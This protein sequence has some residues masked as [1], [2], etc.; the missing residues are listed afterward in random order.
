MH[1]Y[2]YTGKGKTIHSCGQLEWYKN[3]ANNKSIKVPGSL[4]SIETNDG[5][6]ATIPINIKVSLPYVQIQPYTDEEW[7]TLLPHIILTSDVDWDPTVLD[8][9]LASLALPRMLAIS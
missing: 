5:G 8:H 3:D 7:D 2:A 9:T 4:Q 1:Q 6:Y